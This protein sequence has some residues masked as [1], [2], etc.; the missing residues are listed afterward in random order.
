M[1]EVRPTDLIW[2]GDEE[3]EVYSQIAASSPQSQ[4]SIP[5]YIN[6]LLKN[7]VMS[8]VRLFVFLS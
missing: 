3:V 7:I 2:E 5:H 8:I 4:Q 6:N 1:K